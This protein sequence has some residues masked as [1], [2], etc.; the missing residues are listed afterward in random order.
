MVGRE[1]LTDLAV[2]LARTRVAEPGV[3]RASAVIPPRAGSLAVLT[4]HRVAQPDEEPDLHPG[5]ISA[6]PEAFAAQMQSLAARRPVVDLAAVLAARDGAPLPPGAVLITFDDGYRD[7]ARHAW[8]VLRALRLPACLFVPT[9]YPGRQV[10]FWW[11]R[12]AAAI[13]L[14]GG[15]DRLPSPIGPL[16]LGGSAQRTMAL[17]RIQTWL[18]A[19]PHQEVLDTVAAIAQAAGLPAPRSAVLDWDALR[20]LAASGLT[21]APHTVGHPLLTR[22]PLDQVVSEVAGSLADVERELGQVPPALA[23]PSGAQ[24][25]DVVQAVREAGIR[26]AF[27]T[28]RGGNRLDH[29]DWLQMRRINVGGRAPVALVEAQLLAWAGGRRGVATRSSV[30]DR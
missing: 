8:P 29:L 18:K 1:K 6:S 28:R 5:L 12:L 23:Y 30:A 3:L 15:P 9:G 25:P 22:V 10:A 16:A 11:D 13:L 14:P 17:R 19:R 20:S 2:A 7:F 4:Y 27:T 21:I 26:V 24:A